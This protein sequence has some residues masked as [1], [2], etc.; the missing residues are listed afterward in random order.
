MPVL[1]KQQEYA[2]PVF[3]CWNKNYSVQAM[4]DTCSSFNLISCEYAAMLNLGKSKAEAIQLES[5]TGTDVSI[6]RSYLVL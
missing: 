4:I 6:D 2:I 3:M 1:D 5:I